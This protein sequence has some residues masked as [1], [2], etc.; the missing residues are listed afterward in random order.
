MLSFA[1]D[2]THP[3][4][5]AHVYSLFDKS[6]G[7]ALFC[8]H[9]L[10]CFL[11]WTAECRVADSKVKEVLVIKEMSIQLRA[12]ASRCTLNQWSQM[13]WVIHMFGKVDIMM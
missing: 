5:T 11:L 10:S 3:S 1:G 2:T 8:P 9:T 4:V 7:F 12:L 13:R 6:D